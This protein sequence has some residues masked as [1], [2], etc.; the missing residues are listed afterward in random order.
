MENKKL[1]SRDELYFLVYFSNFFIGV[2]ILS[3][4]YHFDSIHSF[5]IFSGIEPIP[6]ILLYLVFFNCIYYFLKIISKKHIIKNFISF[7]KNNTT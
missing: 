2:M 7:V 3:Y 1:I 4:E 6:F 5:L